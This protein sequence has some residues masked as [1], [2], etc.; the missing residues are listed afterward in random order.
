MR[1]N[2]TKIV[3]NKAVLLRQRHYTKKMQ[4]HP[5]INLLYH[6]ETGDL[7]EQSSGGVIG[8]IAHQAC[9]L[10]IHTPHK[11]PQPMEAH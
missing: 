4:A 2:F 11:T 6:T 3:R 9:S 7:A 5:T 8:M 10:P 1:D